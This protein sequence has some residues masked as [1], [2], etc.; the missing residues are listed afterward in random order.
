MAAR[1]FLLWS[2]LA[3]VLGLLVAGGGYWSYWNFYARFQPVLIPK[4]QADIQKLLD[5]SGWVS[6][7]KAQGGPWIYV[8][9]WR[10]CD[11][12][13]AYEREEFPKLQAA[14]VDTRVVVYARPAREGLSQS[15]P[16]ERATIAA[17]WLDRDWAL[18]QRWKTVTSRA[19]TGPS[20]T[21]C[22][23]ICAATTSTA[24][25]RWCCGATRTAT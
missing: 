10:T 24:P 16:S 17:L 4:N 2:L 21:S 11:A 18:Y 20:P 1:R 22:R 25:I 13:T 5:E 7:G 3:A 12:C 8:V 15:T 14:N 6:P 19:W 9:G 23:P